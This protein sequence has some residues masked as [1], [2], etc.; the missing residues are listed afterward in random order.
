MPCVGSFCVTCQLA[1]SIT[2][3]SL[4]RPQVSSTWRSSGVKLKCQQ[5]SPTGT[6]ATLSKLRASNTCSFWSRAA[7]TSTCLPVRS[8]A[9]P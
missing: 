1:V 4:E 8:N 7:A 9:T 2:S 6:S 5:R 3:V